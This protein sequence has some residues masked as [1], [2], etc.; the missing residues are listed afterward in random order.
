M[1]ITNMKKTYGTKVALDIDELEFEDGKIYAIVGANGS[2][3]STLIRAMAGTIKTDDGRK[4]DF[5]GKTHC[6][7]PQ[8]NHAF[9]MSTEKNVLLGAKGEDAKTS[10]STLMKELKIDSLAKAKAHRLSGGETAKMALCRTILS[11]AQVLLL[12]E[13]TAA[14]DVES[15]LLAED[16]IRRYN[17]DNGATIILITHSLSQAKRLADEIIF[18]KDGKILE[19]GETGKILSNPE[20]AETKEFLEF[21]S[22]EI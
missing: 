11:G 21:F 12:D 2:G 18:M 7:M 17:K 8:K 1:K 3:K 5:G 22:S 10:A 16:I 6:Y 13:P 14:M 20:K 19:K 9:K 4:A 15:T